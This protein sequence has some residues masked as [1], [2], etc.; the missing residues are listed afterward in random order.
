MIYLKIF[1]NLH[2]G[3]DEKT[4]NPIWD[5]QIRQLG[6][7]IRPQICI[8]DGPDSILSLLTTLVF[9]ILHSN[10]AI[11]PRN[12]LGKNVFIFSFMII[13][14]SHQTIVVVAIFLLPLTDQALW[15]VHIQNL[16]ESMD[17]TGSLQGPLDWGSACH[18]ATTDREQHKQR[19]HTTY[20]I[21]RLGFK[22]AIPVFYL[23]KIFRVLN[24]AAIVIYH[25]TAE[26]VRQ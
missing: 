4:K 3:T 18:K 2:V 25:S 12:R 24:R 6:R 26:F 1:L 10:Y 17:L 14:L 16:S 5:P 22:A 11:I 19:K 13:F 8:C 20:I 7:A 9:V 23:A 21:P 15:I